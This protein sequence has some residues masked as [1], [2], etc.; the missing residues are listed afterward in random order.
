[1]IESFSYA[2]FLVEFLYKLSLA[3]DAINTL[4]AKK[5]I[6]SMSLVKDSAS[7]E[8]GSNGSI[9]VSLVSSFV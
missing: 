8:N 5:S 7:F 2:V 6:N 3:L 1:M 4:T 9:S